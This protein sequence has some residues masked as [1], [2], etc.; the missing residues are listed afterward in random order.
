MSNSAPQGGPAGRL[1]ISQWSLPDTDFARDVALARAAGLAG[2]HV[3]ERKIPPGRE[4]A[5]LG[6][7]RDAGLAFAGIISDT[8]T[9]LPA[10]EEFG[11]R[12]DPE[13]RLADLCAVLDRLGP[14]RPD[15]F[16]V[17]TGHDPSRPQGEVR[18][19]VVK[20][21]RTLCRHAAKYAVDVVVE[22]MRDDLK[23]KTSFL[24]TLPDA[25][26]LIDE[27]GAD[28]LKVC[29]D[30][31]HLY[32]TPDILAHTEHYADSIGS[33]QVSDRRKA[34]RHARDRLFAGDGIVDLAG[35]VRALEGGGYSG[36]YHLFVASHKELEDSLWRLPP[37]EFVR[38]NRLGFL[39]V[40]D[41]VGDVPRRSPVFPKTYRTGE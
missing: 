1:S 14:Y 12:E 38:R 41:A 6:R 35:M 26:A 8:V 19:L 24:R 32:D 27:V 25:I 40:L 10:H 28:N 7:L 34:L 36:W 17:I 21:M 29:Y 22:P 39:R 9:L 33:V 11:G 31:F 4:A 3:A 15:T 13:E 16:L 5:S 20:H 30:I 2:L 23:V 37:D 18:D